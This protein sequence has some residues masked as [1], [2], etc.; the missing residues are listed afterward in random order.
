MST[1]KRDIAVAEVLDKLSQVYMPKV[2]ARIHDLV[3]H[4]FWQGDSV[5]VDLPHG[6]FGGHVVVVD[7]N[8][9]SAR[10]RHDDD[11]RPLFIPARRPHSLGLS[12]SI[13]LE[14]SIAKDNPQNYFYAVEISDSSSVLP[15]IV[16]VKSCRLSR[17]PDSLKEIIIKTFIELSIAAPSSAL[18]DTAHSAAHSRV[19]PSPVGCPDLSAD[20]SLASLPTS[21][22]AQQLITPDDPARNYNNG[23]FPSDM[24]HRPS[25]GSSGSKVK[26]LFRRLRPLASADDSMS[27]SSAPTSFNGS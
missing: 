27:G 5:I 10:V 15:Y 13:S 14:E 1:S 19:H 3:L 7:V 12:T 8:S 23:N 2:I 26:T 6:S 17:H 16:R 20:P 22:N 11:L 9:T 25:Q 21:P 24:V 18:L 4:R